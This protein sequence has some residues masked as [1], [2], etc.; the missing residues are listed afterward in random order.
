MN[1]ATRFALLAIPF[2]SYFQPVIIMSAIPF[3]IVGAF[4][5]HIVMGMELSTAT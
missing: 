2:K 3:G 5:G 4:L 1:T